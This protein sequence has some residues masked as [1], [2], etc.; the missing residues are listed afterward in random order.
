[1]TYATIHLHLTPHPAATSLATIDYACSA[2][3][4]FE[5]R[6][7]ASSTQLSIRAPSNWMTGAM[8]ARIARELEAT[9]TAKS[10]ELEAYLKK[11]ASAEGISLD[12][13]HVPQ[14]WPAGMADPARFGRVA[15]LC[16]LGLQRG[17]AEA[18]MAIED[19]VFGAGRPCLLYPDTSTQTF[20]LDN[21]LVCWD[22]SRSAARAMSDALPLL[23]NARNVHLAIFRGEKEIA[24]PEAGTA[25][26]D[27][28]AAHGVRAIA[29]E[30]E[31]GERTIGQAILDHAA[32]IG[33]DLI[34]LGA[35]GHSRFQEFLLG[36]ATKSLLD[37]SSIPLL[38]SH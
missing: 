13:T 23:H 33:A 19:W 20:S 11:K 25:A 15:D 35:F 31:T 18:R 27:F 24:A 8:L 36:G 7:K 30:V 14:H 37:T 6:L 5:A 34:V 26:I 22:F 9:T 10:T 32:S 3:K 12:V 1:M 21:I 4:L 16:V 2:A 28:R 38:M 29:E 17:G